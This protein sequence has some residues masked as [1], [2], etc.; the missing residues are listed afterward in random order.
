[1]RRKLIEALAADGDDLCKA[2]AMM[3]GRIH[4]SPREAL[5]RDVAFGL[6]RPSLWSPNRYCRLIEARN[7]WIAVNLAREDDRQMIPAWIGSAPEAD[8]W[9]SLIAAARTHDA[10]GLVAQ[11]IELH[12]PV[13]RVGE[14][15]PQT[16]GGERWARG[17]SAGRPTALDLSALWAGPY[18][19]GLL[20]E[21]GVDVT[22]IESPTRP[23]P[24]R[25]T[26]P[27]LD[28]R[29]NGAKHRR[30]L[31]LT[32]PELTRLIVETDILITSARRHAL[33]RLNLTEE[34]L[35]A[36]N[37]GLI[38]VAITAYGQAGDAGMRVGF[39]DDCAA[40]GGLVVWQK[41]RPRFLGDA[42]ADP[43]SGIAAATSALKMLAAGKAGLI[44]I[45]LARV[46]ARMAGRLGLR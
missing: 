22:R 38:W 18:C 46:A 25:Q 9:H 8:P 40:A 3:G 32:D 10:A 2:A 29:L 23:D 26:S 4:F 5:S 37:P 12:L 43:L 36:L 42:L 17:N 7:G 28:Y 14:A 13:A 19:G 20:A 33:A 44:D 27:L 1:M 24:T 34:R 31:D 30:T 21:A 39:G 11:G 35:F 45:A 41:G 15:T 16:G 6:K